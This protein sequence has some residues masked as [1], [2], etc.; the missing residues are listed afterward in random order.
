MKEFEEKQIKNRG[1]VMGNEGIEG[2]RA[3]RIANGGRLV[4][5]MKKREREWNFRIQT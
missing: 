5:G 2:K 3:W 4:L 1:K